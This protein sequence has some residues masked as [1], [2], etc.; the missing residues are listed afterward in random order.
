M[1]TKVT[2]TEIRILSLLMFGPWQVSIVVLSMRAHLSAHYSTNLKIVP[3]KK[4]LALTL[5]G[6]L[7]TALVP[8]PKVD[9]SR[10]GARRP[11]LLVLP[12]VLPAW[13]F[14]V[15]RT[16]QVPANLSSGMDRWGRGIGVTSQPDPYPPCEQNH[17]HE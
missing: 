3:N 5:G 10:Q 17:T 13:S 14:H 4:D 9:H 6:I 1:A 11:S 15:D 2:S 7:T 12:L 8:I 16:G